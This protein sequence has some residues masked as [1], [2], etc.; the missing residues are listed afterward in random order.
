MKTKRQKHMTQFLVAALAIVFAVGFAPQM[1][2]PVF[3]DNADP[4]LSLG[5][6]VLAE[7]AAEDGAQ[8]VNYG[9]REWYVIACDGK[10]GNG[11]TIT[12]ENAG[13]DTVALHPEGALTLYQKGSVESSVFND[14]IDPPDHYAYGYVD[15]EGSTPSSLRKS[16]ES[17]YL[18]GDN[19]R[20]SPS[21]QAAII[22]RTLYGGN[23]PL[24]IRYWPTGHDKNTI[25]NKDLEGAVVWP[26]SVAE[27]E[28]VAGSILAD[29]SGTAWLRTP[30]CPRIPR[31]DII[32]AATT[33]EGCV[34]VNG[35][36]VRHSGGIR[37]AFYLDMYPIVFTSSAYGGKV[38][39]KI[40]SGSLKKVSENQDGEWKVSLLDPG[41][42]LFEVY[43]EEPED[44]V[45]AKFRYVGAAL[46]EHEYISAVITDSNLNVKYYGKLKKCV[47]IVDASGELTVNLKGK[48][49]D[50]DFLYIFN[51]TCNGDAK[52]D[53]TS[54]L[55]MVM[56]PDD[57]H[58]LSKIDPAAAT[59]TDPGNT[60]YHKCSSCG[61]F[62]VD[63]GGS[64][65]IEKDSWVISCPSVFNIPTKTYNGKRIEPGITVKDTS[66]HVISK[67]NYVVKYYNN[68]NA[69]TNAKAKVTF[70][71]DSYSG[72]KTLKFTIRKAANTL[73]VKGKTAA[74]KY[75]AVKKKTRVLGVSK[76]IKFNN[77][78]QGAIT[79]AKASGNKKII[80][81]KKTGKITI[82]KGLKKGTYK[83]IVKV[84]AAG[85]A[86]YKASAVKKVAF[87]IRVK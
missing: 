61:R 6:D 69:G 32:C 11:N 40:G 20:L 72:E 8:I 55:K 47:E 36:D 15:Q 63:E 44:C 50:G 22:P 26:L 28:H 49:N 75:S 37:P 12:Y 16:I 82:K 53:Y 62:F 43:P 85:N 18:S 25:A 27:A 84:K 3:A 64:Y 86:N 76:A 74:V 59:M 39:G 13:G 71:G 14:S 24:D 68:I 78:G 79:Y 45:T 7:N 83:V 1:G 48:V 31:L 30:G 5:T 35:D 67:D 73:K 42:Q 46:G 60:A 38:S 81:A 66:G 58:T 80:I 52:T 21:E 19:P 33:H 17:I 23:V 41:H 4:D 51:E 10:D 9:G 77:K 87:K 56:I 2:V 70:K 54:P 65:Q 57:H 34:D 29:Q